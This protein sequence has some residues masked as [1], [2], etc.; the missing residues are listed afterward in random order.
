MNLED[1]VIATVHSALT[2]AIKTKLSSYHGPLDSLIKQSIEK[3]QAEITKALDAAMK[4]ALQGEFAEALADACTRKLA[5]VLISKMEG[6]LEKR[7]GEL[8]SSPEF[9][10][11][12]TVAIDDI[13]K[14][15]AK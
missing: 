14:S 5:K 6:E 12:L 9:R 3:H 1:Q 2:E 4:G 8:R 11:R 15:L 7:V 10:S 13:V